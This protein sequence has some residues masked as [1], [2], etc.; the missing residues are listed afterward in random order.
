MAPVYSTAG[1]SCPVP[2]R[3]GRGLSGRRTRYGPFVTALWRVLDQEPVPDL[4]AYRAAGGGAGLGAATRLGPAATIDEVDAAGLRGRGGAGFPA[5]RKW[6]TVAQNRSPVLP[7]TIVVNASEGE[8]GSFKDRTLMR[9]NPYRLIEGALIA[10]LAVGANGVIFATK[11]SFHTELDRL[12]SA[13]DE[14]R[15]AGW[16]KEVEFF[17]VEGPSEYLYGEE[18]ALLEVV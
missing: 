4:G 13:L 6:R 10:A 17:V 1:R 14:C 12:Q 8:P 15:K 16:D 11:A 18:T 5:G 2:T 3:T 9:R 7:S